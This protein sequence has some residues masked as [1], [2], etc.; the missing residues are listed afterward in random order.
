M[1]R[2]TALKDPLAKVLT[3]AAKREAVAHLQAWNGMSERRACH[4][5]EADR[6]S[7]RYSST[8]DDDT[9]LRE[10]LHELAN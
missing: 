1:L 10:K 7:V 8:R 2:Q 9:A 4:V 3:P 6:K 5:I